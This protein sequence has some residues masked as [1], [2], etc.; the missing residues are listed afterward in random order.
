MLKRIIS[1][2]N[3]NDIKFYPESEVEEKPKKIILRIN[4]DL[5]V[6]WHPRTRFVFKSKKE[7][8]VIGKLTDTDTQIDLEESDIEICKE[9]KFQYQFK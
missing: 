5:D 6:L 7:R 1:K 4:K 2:I 8:I 3:A 9:W